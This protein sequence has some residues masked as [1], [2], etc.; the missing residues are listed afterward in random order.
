MKKASKKPK[1][2]SKKPGNEA[3][4]PGLEKAFSIA[5][6]SLGY[7]RKFAKA[8]KLKLSDD[9]LVSLAQYLLEL[10]DT[11]V[12]YHHVESQDRSTG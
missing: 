4:D 6:L 5:T 10:R 3:S 1:E 11:Y 12:P 2:A 9:E 7:A 8:H